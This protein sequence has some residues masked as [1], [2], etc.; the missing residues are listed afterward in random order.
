ML[1]LPSRYEGLPLALVEAMWCGRPAVV[2]E[3]GGNAELCVDDETG[4]VAPAATVSSFTDTL[5]R[6]WERRK[7]WPGL[8][9]A[10]R[11]RVE[12]QIPK[13]PVG[14]FCE[15]LKSCA[16]ARSAEAPAG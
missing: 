13:D 3:V 8:G 15:Q 12:N 6:A 10:A 5:Q 14:V 7:E 11:A 4:F 9:Q 16:T 1:V 2:T